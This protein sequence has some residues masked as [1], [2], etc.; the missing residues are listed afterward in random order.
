MLR[1]GPRRTDR[2]HLADATLAPMP[3]AMQHSASATTIPPSAMSCALSSAPDRTS[4]RT[5]LMRIT[6]SL[7]ILGG[8]R[9]GRGLTLE[10]GDLRAGA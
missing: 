6:D 3:P 9:P 5:L 4:D 8:E 2:A 1:R 10:L 7:H